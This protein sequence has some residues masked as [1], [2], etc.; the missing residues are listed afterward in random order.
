MAKI[1]PN[2]L[3]SR[4]SIKGKDIILDYQFSLHYY[5]DEEG[6]KQQG[7]V[8]VE[9]Y[10]YEDDIIVD[11][12]PVDDNFGVIDLEALYSWANKQIAKEKEAP[13][14]DRL[15]YIA[16]LFNQSTLVNEQNVEKKTTIKVDDDL[17]D[18]IFNTIQE[19]IE[20]LS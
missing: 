18:Y 6:L 8:P 19:A 12:L 15:N 1:N 10:P 20:K 7:L 4:V 17:R 14:A 2:V 11:Y 13:L 5:P 16:G 3:N 9:M